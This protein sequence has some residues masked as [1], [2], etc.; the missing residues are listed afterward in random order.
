MFALFSALLFAFSVGSVLCAPAS[1]LIGRTAANS[2]VDTEYLNVLLGMENLQIAFYTK[3][4]GDFNAA[5]FS[6]AEFQPFVVGRYQQVLQQEI[7]HARTIQGLLGEAAVQPC[8]YTFTFTDPQSFVVMS[9]Q[10]EAI[11]ASTYQGV[12]PL[13][14]DKNNMELVA[15]IFSVEARHDSWTI[16]SPQPQAGWNSNLDTPLDISDA[17]SF[18]LQF[19]NYCPPANPPLSSTLPPLIISP[20]TVTANQAVSLNFSSASQMPSNM[21]IAW[22]NGGSKQ[23]SN[24]DLNTMTTIVPEGLLGTT[25]A[26]V[27]SPS[28]ESVPLTTSAFVYAPFGSSATV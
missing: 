22:N 4:L 20:L 28:D 9:S 1:S 16:S 8:N 25:Y 6:N 11:G 5:A 2:S 10:I 18:L 13:I 3:G 7:E 12:L 27:V 23:F 24:I 26:A 15:S 14:T 21:S 19:I 17:V